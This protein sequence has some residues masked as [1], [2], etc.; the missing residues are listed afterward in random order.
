M[1]AALVQCLLV[2]VEC[3]LNLVECLLQS[4]LNASGLAFLVCSTH[5]LL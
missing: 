1:F 4:I 2:H 3:L 5:F